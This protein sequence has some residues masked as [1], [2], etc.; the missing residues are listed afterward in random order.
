M[1]E[2]F[3]R[4]GTPQD[5]LVG[6]EV[7]L[8]AL[9]RFLAIAHSTGRARLIVG[10]AGVGKTRILQAAAALARGS[11][12]RVLSASGVEFE[13]DISYSGQNHLLHP[14]FDKLANLDSLHESALSVAL[15]L[16]DGAAPQLLVV[17]NAALALRNECG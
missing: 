11:G 16:G 13:A 14:L 4:L 3:D 17:Y 8:A 7:E 1:S 12:T 15:G 9:D 6:R 10:E 2:P 5:H